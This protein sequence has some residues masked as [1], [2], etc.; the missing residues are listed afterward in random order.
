VE[1][2]FIANLLTVLLA[3][4]IGR[5]LSRWLKQPI[6]LGEIVL[7]MLLGNFGLIVI[8]ETLSNL[9]DLGVLFLLFSAGFAINLEEFKRVCRC[10]LVATLTDV[11]IS[12]TLGYLTARLFGFPELTSMFVGAALTATS[13]GIQTS[14]LR[15]FNV[16]RTRIGTFILGVAIGDDVAGIL[17][18]TILGSVVSL[19]GVTL[20]GIA[21]IIIFAAAFFLFSLTVG[22]RIMKKLSRGRVM[23]RESLLL[24]SLIIILAFGITAK[25]MGLEVIIGAFVAG[26]VLGQSY[27]ARGIIEEI[28][29]FGDAFFVPIFFIIMGAGFDLAHLSVGYFTVALIVVAIL[30]KIIG[31]GIGAR[32]AGFNFRQSL[33]VGT[34]MIPRAEVCLIIASVGLRYGIISQEIAS[35]ILAMIIVIAIITPPLLGIMLRWMNSGPRTTQLI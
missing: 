20:E 27:F 13:V 8:T 26:L 31:C 29:I 23:M 24:L 32:F 16:L 11:V 22:V 2:S 5:G 9:A 6:V 19:G 4:G 1:I 33:A 28:S 30:S 21:L 14:L 25:E 17:I 10:S 7:G 15:E 12:F 35:S 34:A 3:A 18:I